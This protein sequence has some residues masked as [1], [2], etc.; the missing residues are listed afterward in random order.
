MRRSLSH[1]L[2]LTHVSQAHM[3]D[4]QLM[5]LFVLGS[6]PLDICSMI[7]G[8]HAF[9]IRSSTI[10]AA[11]FF[12]SQ[13]TVP[14]APMRIPVITVLKSSYRQ[15]NQLTS[16]RHLPDKYD[17][18]TWRQKQHPTRPTSQPNPPPSSPTYRRRF[19]RSRRPHAKI[20][21]II[22]PTLVNRILH[23]I[24]IQILDSHLHIRHIFLVLRSHERV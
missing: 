7:V 5:H 11:F 23:S 3:Y 22:H 1:T 4:G 14:L 16:T 9:S 8:S 24:P 2:K 21:R 19:T 20:P 6:L 15:S 13:S 18:H 17:H 12:A 10:A